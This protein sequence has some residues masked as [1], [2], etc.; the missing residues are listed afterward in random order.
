MDTLNGSSA[1]MPLGISI[2]GRNRGV[3]ITDVLADSDSHLP[4]H[5]WAD[6][7]G[8]TRLEQFLGAVLR[9]AHALS[10]APAFGRPAVTGSDPDR[11]PQAHAFAWPYGMHYF[12]AK[13]NVSAPYAGKLFPD[14]R[15]I[16]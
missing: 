16:H 3:W 8:E 6:L 9:G 15:V 2:H 7:A 14:G 12:G 5:K 10:H 1:S 4:G 13:R 11:V